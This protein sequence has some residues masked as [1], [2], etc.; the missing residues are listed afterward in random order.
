MEGGVMEPSISPARGRL[1]LQPLRIAVVQSAAL[2]IACLISYELVT[3]L[4]AHIYS[5]SA[6]DH[7]LGGMW[8]V[9]ATIFVYRFSYEEGLA[10]AV[11]RMAATVI[12]FVLCLVYLLF[13]PFSVWG[14]ATLIG[15][16]ALVTTLVGRPRDAVTTG[17][18][19]TVVMVVAPQSPHNA[20]EQPILRLV[21]TL[22]GV[23]VG[24]SVA[25]IGLRMTDLF[26]RALPSWY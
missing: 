11:S 25:W 17:I 24:L 19:T 13:L 4:L 1:A 7:R 23:A 15:V 6:S 8:A 20:W 18:T 26:R 3:Q 22:A 10:A 2:A 9:L 21:D 14:M 16:G 12:S 5:L